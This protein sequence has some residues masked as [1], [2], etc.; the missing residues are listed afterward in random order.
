MRATRGDL[1]RS[2][3][4]SIASPD[5]DQMPIAAQITRRRFG[6]AL[7]PQNPTYYDNPSNRL[8]RPNR[9][10]GVQNVGTWRVVGNQFQ[11]VT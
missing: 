4:T 5:N 7:N 10:G 9:P 8:T 3:Q 6:G 2:A 11:R 1:G